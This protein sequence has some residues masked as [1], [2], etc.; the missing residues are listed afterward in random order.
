MSEIRFSNSSHWEN[1]NQ[2][3]SIL[4]SLHQINDGDKVNIDTRGFATPFHVV[5]SACVINHKNLTF[6]ISDIQSDMSQ[7]LKIVHFPE[8][9]ISNRR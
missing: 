7:Y 9:G 6:D 5:P 4:K 3:I 1:L 8:G 2:L